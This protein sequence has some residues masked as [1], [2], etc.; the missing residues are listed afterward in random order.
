MAGSRRSS[1]RSVSVG[2]AVLALHV[3]LAWM[4]TRPAPAS[5]MA[6]TAQA[7]ARVQVRLL[8]WPEPRPMA[9]KPRPDPPARQHER[10]PAPPNGVVVPEPVS[11]PITAPAR[12]P[13]VEAVTT[14]AIPPTAAA[15]EPERPLDLRLPRFADGPAARH[16]PALDDPRA[17]TPRVALGERMARAIGTDDQVTEE[18]RGNGR[19]RIRQGAAC[20]DV[21]PSRAAEIDPIGQSDRPKP[22]LVERC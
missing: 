15:S 18:L 3:I 11:A 19:R 2:C 1:R 17:N 8:P 20:V 9:A 10:R 12:L 4:L 21:R 6:A 22:S 13:S 7:A 16:N 14:A 5:R